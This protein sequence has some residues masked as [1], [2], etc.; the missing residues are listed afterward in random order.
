MKKTT[1]AAL[2]LAGALVLGLAGCG[3]TSNGAADVAAVPDQAESSTAQESSA[4]A[5]GAEAEPG[6]SAILDP[7][8]ADSSRKLV[9]T[10][11]VSME[12]TDFDSARQA[13]LGAV[14]TCGAYLQSS[15]SWG[16][17][18]S[19][20]RCASYTVRVPA[21]RYRDF[22]ASLGGAGSVL[23]LQERAED[24]SAQYIDMEARLTS[25]ETQRDRLNA[26]AA[27]A[28]TT[29]D[30][31]KIE[32]QLSDVQYQIESYTAQMR[33]LDNRIT[34]STV[35]ICLDEVAVLAPTGTSFADR[36]AAAFVGGWRDAGAFL[37]DLALQLLYLL[38]L[39][40]VLA[41]LAV[42]L[43]LLRRRHRR[44]KAGRRGSPPAG[45]PPAGS[46]TTPEPPKAP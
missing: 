14:E 43:I 1:L 40:L 5:E 35:E 4:A 26:L 3:A 39:I 19:A 21:E 17:A 13:I 9:Y 42:A 15:E 36:A 8:A 37:Q 38:P 20:N 24:V 11:D 44:R 41:L 10:A 25:L 2:L 18:E 27:Q 7:A 31:L 28:D 6:S 46:G 33:A 29:A 22:L 32:S 23:S 30:L 12:S 45:W 34:Y 16:N